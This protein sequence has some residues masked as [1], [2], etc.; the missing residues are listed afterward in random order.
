MVCV[1]EGMGTEVSYNTHV[2]S[3]PITEIA[4]YK[5][6]LPNVFD[7]PKLSSLFQFSPH[8][9]LYLVSLLCFQ[10]PWTLGYIRVLLSP[11]YFQGLASPTAFQSPSIVYLPSPSLGPFQN[12]GLKSTHSTQA[13]VGR[14]P[15]EAV[16]INALVWVLGTVGVS[17]LSF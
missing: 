5:Y 3:I 12:P 7:L 9:T 16:S 10:S 2:C 15:W 4:V 8:R 6:P 14:P 1:L 13:H 17:V 11:G